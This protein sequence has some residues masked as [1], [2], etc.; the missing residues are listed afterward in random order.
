VLL[1]DL[2]DEAKLGYKYASLMKP[3]RPVQS[4]RTTSLTPANG[5]FMLAAEHVN[6]LKA[7]PTS[8]AFLLISNIQ[9]LD[10]LSAEAR[11]FG[12]FSK[13]VG[14]D[15][16][17]TAESGYLGKVSR[18]SS[19]GHVHPGPLSASLNITRKVATMTAAADGTVKLFVAPLTPGG[20]TSAGSIPLAAE[21]VSL[22]R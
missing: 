21:D 22:I 13:Q 19:G 1:N 17:A 14:S 2:R 15:T 7:E 12:I 10:K 11:Q 9:S 6:R 4:M 5:S 18:V 20:V 16:H 8:P 3:A